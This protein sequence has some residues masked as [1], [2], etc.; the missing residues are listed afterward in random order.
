VVVVLSSVPFVV[1]SGDAID[2]QAGNDEVKVGQQ[3]YKSA[4]RF[5]TDIRYT[6]IAE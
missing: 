1:Q 4:A 2:T 5:P 3:D 6:T